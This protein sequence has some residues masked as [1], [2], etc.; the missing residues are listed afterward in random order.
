MRRL[1]ERCRGQE[2]LGRGGG[3]AQEGHR[4]EQT[5]ASSTVGGGDRA[6]RSCKG[7][8]DGDGPAEMSSLNGQQRASFPRRCGTPTDN[9]KDSASQSCASRDQVMTQWALTMR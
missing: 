5:V 8:R 6:P 7:L 1:R 3:R 4:K 9:R 2:E